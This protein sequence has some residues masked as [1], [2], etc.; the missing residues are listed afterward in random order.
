MK[1]QARQVVLRSGRPYAIL[2]KQL[3]KLMARFVC[4]IQHLSRRLMNPESHLKKTKVSL[5][6]P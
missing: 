5:V 4:F 3:E 1:E 6:Q 2:M